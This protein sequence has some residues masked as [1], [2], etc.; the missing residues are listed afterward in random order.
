MS[1]Y[2]SYAVRRLALTIPILWG[3]FTVT[4]I[5]FFVVPGDPARLLMGQHR[6]A[7]MEAAMRKQWGLDQPKHIQYWQF[8]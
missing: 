7:A 1:S 3:V 6:D 4:F 8:L 2:F 5:L